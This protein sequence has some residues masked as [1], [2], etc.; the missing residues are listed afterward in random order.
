MQN[1]TRT[2]RFIPNSK[3][4]ISV[5]WILLLFSRT[6]FPDIPA[7]Y[8]NAATGLT[9]TALQAAL[10]NII[11]N[12]N[13]I[14]Y[15]PGIWNAFYTT[16][17]KPNGKVWDMYSDIPDGT[18]NGNPVYVYT[19][20]TD[21]CGTA[22]Q[23]GDCYSREHSFPKSWFGDASPMYTDLFH[24]V[25]ADQYVN[26]MRSNY[27]Y[28]AVTNPTWTSTNGCK[29][30]PCT[31]PGY[32][33]TVFEPRDEY[34]GDFARNYFYMAVRYY[35]E[36]SSWPGSPMVDGSQP[37]PWALALL[38]QWH[39]QDPVSQKE[40]DRNNAIYAIQNNRNPFI[41]HPEYVAA[42]WTPGTG[43]NPEPSQH[44]TNFSSHSVHLQW[45]DATGTML[46][47]GYLVRMSTTG[48]SDIATPVDGVQVPNGQYDRNV[49]YGVEEVWFDNLAPN[50]TY[51][52]KVFGYSFTST[53]IDYKTD[54]PVIQTKQT[55]QP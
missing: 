26:N 2:T 30:G 1:F 37:K 14:S 31:T 15:T 50:T 5:L 34:K 3:K 11:K 28:G 32:T 9:G 16:D 51:Y 55:T 20:G 17:D 43:V 54:G 22:S 13:S 12:H 42:I 29:L 25:P 35:T 40:I 19:F 23:E 48:Y 44:A 38:I 49:L 24:I 33:G 18:A 39:N 41:D 10:H 53:G 4:I 21:Q 27:P 6:A 47:D 8:Y 45:I 46:P 52:F 7:G 36:D